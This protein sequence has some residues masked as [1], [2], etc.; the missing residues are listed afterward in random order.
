MTPTLHEFAS[1]DPEIF[2]RL[3]DLAEPEPWRHESE[4]GPEECPILRKYVNNTF[5][6]A[7]A[8]DRIA[9]GLDARHVKVATYNTG[10]QT[11][12]GEE[13]FGLFTEQ[14]WINREQPYYLAEF[15][16]RGSETLTPFQELPVRPTFF[17]TITEV[18]YDINRELR[19]DYATILTRFSADL[20]GNAARPEETLR[21]AIDR[22][23]KQVQLNFRLAYPQ[24]FWPSRAKAGRVQFLLPLH[25][26]NNSK[27]N[28]ALSVDPRPGFYQSA[29]VLPLYKAYAN[30]R[31]IGKFEHDWLGPHHP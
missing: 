16:A 9:R 30:A 26:E 8:Q 28:L 10:L 7:A 19:T 17:D 2:R 12:A 31:L 3:A 21:S 22:A 15:L 18:V 5:R 14:T 6:Q 11:S 20:L 23:E 4:P 1:W 29:T 25:L 27:V 24:I 13:I